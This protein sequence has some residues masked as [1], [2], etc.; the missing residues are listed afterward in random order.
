MFGAPWKRL[1]KPLTKNFW[2]ITMTMP[3]SSICTIPMATWLPSK[4]AG[5]GQPN[6]MCPMEKYMSTRR[7]PSDAINLFFRTGVS[8]SLS[9]SSSAAILA[10]RLPADLAL[11]APLGDAP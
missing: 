10:V 3:A 4:K 7:K 9:A 2:L 5:S 6:I 1:L 8:W 11:S